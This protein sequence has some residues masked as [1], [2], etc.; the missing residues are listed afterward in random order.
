MYNN[1]YYIKDNMSLTSKYYCKCCDYQS[2]Y[3]SKYIRHMETIKHK[4]NA[5]KY[6]KN[7][8]DTSSQEYINYSYGSN[9]QDKKKDKNNHLQK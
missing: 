4:L 5:D 9:K 2:D 1:I 7:S 6:Q 8:Q 3:S